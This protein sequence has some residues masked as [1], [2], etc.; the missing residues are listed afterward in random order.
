MA[1]RS[2][3]SKNPV[4]KA[5]NAMFNS[6][7]SAITRSVLTFGVAVTLLATGFGEAFLVPA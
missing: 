6:E 2:R 1:P 3:P 7:N 5:Y 4:T